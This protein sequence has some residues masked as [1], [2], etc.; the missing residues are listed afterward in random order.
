MCIQTLGTIYQSNVD[1]KILVLNNG[2]L[3]MVRQWQE[4]FFDKRYASTEMIN[5]DFQTIS[6]GYFIPSEKVEERHELNQALEK[7]LNHKGSYLLEVK[8]GKENNVFPMVPAGASVSDIR[9]G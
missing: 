8:V 6:K 4:L 5:P 7:M 2:F 3:G 9:L 1:I